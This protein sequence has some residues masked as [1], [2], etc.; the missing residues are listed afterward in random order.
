PVLEYSLPECIEELAT[1]GREID[2][3]LA[4]LSDEEAAKETVLIIKRLCRDLEIPSL[5]E[6]GIDEQLFKDSLEKMATDALDSGSPA[7]NPKIPSKE[8]I[9]QLYKTCYS[10]E[11]K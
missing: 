4:K 8:E 1:I 11:Y 6:W 2:E 3:K 9:L 7:N 10:Y 5:E